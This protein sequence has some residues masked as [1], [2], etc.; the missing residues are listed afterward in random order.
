MSSSNANKSVS[1]VD[2]VHKCTTIDFGYATGLGPLYFF[3]TSSLD[4][5]L[6]KNDMARNFIPV[7]NNGPYLHK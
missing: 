4:I 6:K 3:T 7:V 2:R 1:F 5:V